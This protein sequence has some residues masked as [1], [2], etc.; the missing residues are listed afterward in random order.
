LPATTPPHIKLAAEKLAVLLTGRFSHN[1]TEVFVLDGGR[2]WLPGGVWRRKLVK[3]HGDAVAAM[4]DGLK[5]R[6]ASEA[7]QLASESSAK[8][9]AKRRR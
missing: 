9:S 4:I 6:A 5:E 3:R 7:A 2:C 8:K 1:G